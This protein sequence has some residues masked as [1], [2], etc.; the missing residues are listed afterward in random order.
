MKGLPQHGNP[1][2]SESKKER[3]LA[4]CGPVTGNPVSLSFLRRHFSHFPF[5][6][7]GEKSTIFVRDND[8]ARGTSRQ[9]RLW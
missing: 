4:F 9:R 5:P 8:T 7:W 3:F 1:N 6:R 2:K